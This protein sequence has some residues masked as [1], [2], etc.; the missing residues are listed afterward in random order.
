MPAA[1]R[2]PFA[3]RLLAIAA[4]GAAL[5]LLYVLVLARKVPDIGDAIFFHQQAIA[6][7]HGHGFV[8]P[9]ISAAARHSVP[10]ALHPPLYPLAVSALAHVG[11]MSEVAHRSLGAAFGFGTIILIGL[12]GRRVDGPRTGLVAASLAAVY[13]VLVAADGAMMSETLYGLL[14]ARALLVSLTIVSGRRTVLAAASLGALIG[15]AALT[16]AEGLLLLAL[17]AWPLALRRPLRRLPLLAASTIACLLV[18]SPWLI[19]N[20]SVFHELTLSHNDAT[21]VAGANCRTTYHGVNLGGWD[22][23][24]FSKRRTYDERRQSDRWRAEGLRYMGRHAGRLAV[25]VPLRIMRT[26]DL[27][28]PHRQVEFAESEARWL[29]TA[30]VVAYF[31]LMPFALAGAWLLRRVRGPLFVLLSPVVLVTVVSAVGYG[32]PRFRHPAEIT[33]VVLAAAAIARTPAAVGARLRA[34]TSASAGSPHG[35]V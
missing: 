18:L 6:L 17:L 34:R 19:R 12:I 1:T 27:W 15:L 23:A 9:F 29:S 22:I 3:A 31:L 32:V 24:C 2:R 14:I 21:V 30:G 11:L 10:S 7:A 16:R 20:A 13:P 8:D 33:I 26:W 4:A 28:Q 5:R 35:A 25:V